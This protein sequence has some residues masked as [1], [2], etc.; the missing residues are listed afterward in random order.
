[1]VDDVD[2]RENI[3]FDPEAFFK[4]VYGISEPDGKAVKVVLSFTPH[5]GKYI[6]TKPLHET[7]AIVKQTGKQLVI[8]CEV[9]PNYE[10]IQQ[11]LSYGD[12]V[13]VVKPKAVVEKVKKMVKAMAARYR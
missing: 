1:L 12:Q 10:F 2:F 13:K 6:L 7:Q 8:S 5:Q 11:I 3:D 9:V 4:H